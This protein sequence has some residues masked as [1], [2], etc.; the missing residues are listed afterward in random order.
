M[1]GIHDLI[2]PHWDRILSRMPTQFT[3]QLFR[4]VVKEI[5]PAAWEE[6][7]KQ[8]GPGGRRTGNFYSP[9][10]ILFNFL[11]KKRRS[12][13]ILRLA[14]DVAP[15]GDWGA[16]T[17]AAWE[18]TKVPVTEEDLQLVEGE[19]RLRRHFVVE[20]AAGLRDRFLNHR[21]PLGLYCDMC[22]MTG[23]T[24]DAALKPSLFEAHHNTEGLAARGRGTTR[25]AD[26]ALLCA[27]C[28]RLIHRMI[29]RQGCWF[30]VLEARSELGWR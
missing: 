22:G 25:L 8:Y 30:T 14:H 18:V 3:T 7:V 28:H 13:E 24:V 15:T 1:A 21:G 26:M 27:C 6:A 23:E 16:Q 4:D 2:E 17:V 20:R 19:R 12:G 10:N 5:A 11:D 9:A 29:S